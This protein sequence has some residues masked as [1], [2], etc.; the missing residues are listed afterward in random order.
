M[1]GVAAGI[2]TTPPLT[3][4]TCGIVVTGAE[5]EVGAVDVAFVA[6]VVFFAVAIGPKASL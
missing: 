4:S 2:P 5:D 3:L 1:N 6:V